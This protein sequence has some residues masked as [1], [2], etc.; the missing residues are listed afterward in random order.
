MEEGVDGLKSMHKN[1]EVDCEFGRG[2]AKL[3]EDG[4]T[5]G[6]R[7]RGCDVVKG[8]GSGNDTDCCGV[9]WSSW[10]DL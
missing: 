10:R 1:F 5:G 2:P 3:V 8:G 4:R 9:L 7:G 6:W